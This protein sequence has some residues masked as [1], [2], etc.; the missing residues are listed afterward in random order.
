MIVTARTPPSPAVE[1]QASPSPVF[2]PRN[3]TASNPKTFSGDP[4]K[5]EDWERLEMPCSLRMSTVCK[6]GGG[7]LPNRRLIAVQWIA[8]LRHKLSCTLSIRKGSSAFLQSSET[9]PPSPHIQEWVFLWMFLISSLR[10]SAEHQ[11]LTGT[12]PDPESG[13]KSTSPDHNHPE[14]DLFSEIPG[15]CL[16]SSV[17][18]A[19]PLR[20]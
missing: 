15:E 14:L 9:A 7:V 10:G 6:W 8:H 13:P 1:N 16:S 4:Q 3:H 20:S 18:W 2:L 19:H 5:Q 17:P 12:P 11:T